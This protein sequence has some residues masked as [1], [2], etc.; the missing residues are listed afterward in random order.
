MKKLIRNTANVP[1]NTTCLSINEIINPNQSDVESRLWF[2]EFM[3]INQCPQREDPL[4]N[5]LKDLCLVAE[6][7][8]LI[9]ASHFVKN[10]YKFK[11]ENKN[12]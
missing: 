11:I 2:H 6:K 8:G 9:Y 10:Y 3:K 5:Q 4:E 1:S 7:L 12:A